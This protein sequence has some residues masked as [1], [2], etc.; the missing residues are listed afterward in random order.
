MGLD[1]KRL[2]PAA[3]KQIAEKLAGQVAAKRAKYGNEKAVRTMPN[4]LPRTFDSQREARRYDELRALHEAGVIRD[5]RLQVNFTLQ[6]GYVA[7]DGEV[8]RP[9]VYKADFVYKQFRLIV[10]NKRTNEIQK[11]Y[12]FVPVWRYK[13]IPQMGLPHPGEIGSKRGKRYVDMGNG[14]AFELKEEMVV[15]DVKGVRT[16]EYQMKKKLMQ[17]RYCITIT[18]I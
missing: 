16:P 5:L 4:G 1:I 3:Q 8:V 17:E 15:E 12:D 10:S 11:D 2:G 13:E 14:V 9:I 7:A 18:E 6:E